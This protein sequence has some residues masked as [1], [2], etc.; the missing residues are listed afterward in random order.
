MVERDAYPGTKK[1]N[2]SKCGNTPLEARVFRSFGGKWYCQACLPT[3]MVNGMIDLR[4]GQPPPNGPT[5]PQRSKPLDPGGPEVICPAS[6]CPLIAND[7]S[8]N[9]G[10]YAGTCPEQDDIDHGGCPWWL[11]GCSTGFQHRLV[12]R[13]VANRRKPDPPRTYDCRFADVCSWQKQATKQ[14]KLC[15]PRAAL[16]AGVKPNVVNW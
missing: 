1:F 6:M 5:E 11:V 16:A 2:C 3:P 9:A 15:P 4:P 8:P 12:E 10:I 7:G 14:N 13:A